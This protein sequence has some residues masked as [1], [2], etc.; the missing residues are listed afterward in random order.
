MTLG[1]I[2]GMKRNQHRA[3]ILPFEILRARKW[4]SHF[5]T[6]RYPTRLV[7]SKILEPNSGN[8]H[9]R[10]LLS[11]RLFQKHYER[12][13]NSYSNK[14]TSILKSRRRNT[15]AVD[16]AGVGKQHFETWKTPLKYYKSSTLTHSFVLGKNNPVP[17]LE[18]F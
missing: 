2:L 12:N 13:Y 6:R 18:W 7:A 16:V 3:H 1:G 4:I 15:F 14:Y 5:C 17:K 11:R 8:E 9:S 10:N